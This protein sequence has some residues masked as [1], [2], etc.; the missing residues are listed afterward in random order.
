MD[1]FA[2]SPSFEITIRVSSADLA[3]DVA[4]LLIRSKL[5]DRIEGLCIA[6]DERSAAEEASEAVRPLE[7]G[8]A[9]ADRWP[10]PRGPND[11]CQDP[12]RLGM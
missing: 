5:Y 11:W 8:S 4:A 9:R 1:P 2:D 6:T 12:R 10:G 7:G 3:R